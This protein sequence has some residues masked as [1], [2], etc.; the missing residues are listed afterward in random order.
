MRYVFTI[1]QR[2][3]WLWIT[4]G[5][6]KSI[7]HCQVTYWP[8]SGAMFDAHPSYRHD[9]DFFQSHMHLYTHRY[10]SPS[11]MKWFYFH[12]GHMIWSFCVD[13][14]PV[15]AYQWSPLIWLFGNKH[16]F[17]LGGEICAAAVCK[18]RTY[19]PVDLW[20]VWLFWICLFSRGLWP[21]T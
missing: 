19:D 7:S 14:V 1:S 2:L 11:I 10:G 18:T 12:S 5:F 17:C 15:H 13:L 6:N 3:N 20:V 16:Q 9:I 4:V 8:S 21:V